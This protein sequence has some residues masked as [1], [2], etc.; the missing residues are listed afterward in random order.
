MGAKKITSKE[1]DEVARENEYFFLHFA[2]KGDSGALGIFSYFDEPKRGIHPLKELVDTLDLPYFE[3]Y[4]QDEY[5]FLGNLSD[6]FLKKVWKPKYGWQPAI[7]S[8]YKRRLVTS[9][10]HGYCMCPEGLTELIA[11]TNIDF[12]LK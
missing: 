6:Q 5:D 8:F 12:L 2:L 1:F 7:V 9:T 10:Y 3:M 4:I 11:N